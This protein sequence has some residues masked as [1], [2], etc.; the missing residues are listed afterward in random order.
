[1]CQDPGLVEVV[2]KEN[3]DKICSVSKEIETNRHILVD[4]LEDSKHNSS[5]HQKPTETLESTEELDEYGLPLKPKDDQ[6]NEVK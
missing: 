5:D 3:N 6:A 4:H 1:V 2:V